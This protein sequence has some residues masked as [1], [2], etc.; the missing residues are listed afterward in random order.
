MGGSRKISTR[1]TREELNLIEKQRWVAFVCAFALRSVE[2]GAHDFC[3][4][5]RTRRIN[6]QIQS[7]RSLLEVQTPSAITRIR[8]ARGL[9]ACVLSSWR[10]F[11]AFDPSADFRAHDQEGQVFNSAKVLGESTAC[12]PKW[13]ACR[14]DQQPRLFDF[15]VRCSTAEYIQQLQQS[16]AAS[17]VKNQQ[18]QRSLET[19]PADLHTSAADTPMSEQ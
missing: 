10:Y 12:R 14:L 16:L 3:W 2:D 19:R 13:H 18:L 7:L 6:Q 17:E 8:T 11:S 9:D 5:C 4:A 15:G 1:K